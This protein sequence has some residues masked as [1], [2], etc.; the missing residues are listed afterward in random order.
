MLCMER[1]SAEFALLLKGMD[2]VELEL[3]GGL[4]KEAQI[5]YLAH[6]PDFDVAELGLAAHGMV[7]GGELY[8]PRELRDRARDVLS[9]AW[10]PIDDD[11]H[12]TARPADSDLA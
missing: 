2:T 4:L 7:R 10:G 6:N 5:P 8:V 1:P 12:P 11:G 9:A 3:A